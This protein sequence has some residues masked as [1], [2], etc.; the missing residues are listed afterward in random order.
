ME[1]VGKLLL[2]TAIIIATFAGNAFSGEK[3]NLY[4]QD[5]GKLLSEQAKNPN[6]IIKFSDE[7]GPLL[8]TVLDYDRV[9]G[10]IDETSS[11]IKQ[12]ERFAALFKSFSPI[13][14]NYEAALS[15]LG[16]QYE[17]EYLSGFKIV[18]LLVRTSS[19]AIERQV[20][21]Y[22]LSNPDWAKVMDA[23]K[24]A[25]QAMPALMISSLSEYIKL[26]KFSKKGE[27]AANEII[28]AY[29]ANKTKQSTPAPDAK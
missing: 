29:N 24:S 21:S 12:M 19:N 7:A 8:K 17:T 13:M 10:I 16:S 18:L 15:E 23:A 3:Y 25:M 2:A 11:E 28:T 27:E 6:K 1:K 4:T 26:G 9:T 22:K 20:D 14:K 5:I